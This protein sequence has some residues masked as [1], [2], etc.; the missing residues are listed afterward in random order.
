MVSKVKRCTRCGKRQRRDDGWNLQ[1]IGGY[2]TAL[3]CPECQTPEENAEAA[4]EEVLTDYSTWRT[5]NATDPDVAE[6]YIR[7]LID[8]Y[9]TPEVMRSKADQLAASRPDC[10]A[11]PVALML[12]IADD[13]ES[14]DLYEPDRLLPD[15]PDLPEHVKEIMRRAI[16]QGKGVY[17]ARDENGTIVDAFIPDDGE[18]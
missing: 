16:E 1:W 8:T 6:T 12:R 9:P 4:V 7:G 3:I 5:V 11:G 17:V 15:E 10:V 14:G 13:M 18:S 2:V